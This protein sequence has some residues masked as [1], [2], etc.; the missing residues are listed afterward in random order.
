LARPLERQN[1]PAPGISI[2]RSVMAIGADQFS[3][4][5]LP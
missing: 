2:Q 4:S 1:T 5:S 3:S